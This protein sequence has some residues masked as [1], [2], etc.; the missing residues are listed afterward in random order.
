MTLRSSAT[1]STPL[2]PQDR[3]AQPRAH[4]TEGIERRRSPIALDQQD[5]RDPRPGE[6]RGQFVDLGGT[7]RD[8]RQRRSGDDREVRRLERVKGRDARLEDADPADRALGPVRVETGC[9]PG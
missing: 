8:D 3:Q 9:G 2:D 1:G 4:L 7:R 6:G 5:G